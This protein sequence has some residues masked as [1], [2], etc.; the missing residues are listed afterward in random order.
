[1][2]IAQIG[3]F[4]EAVSLHSEGPEGRMIASLSEGCSV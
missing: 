4:Y 1:M 2:N 3:P